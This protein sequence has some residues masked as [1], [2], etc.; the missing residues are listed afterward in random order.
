MVP[1]LVE[2]SIFCVLVCNFFVN[3][4]K[5]VHDWTS[6]LMASGE[7]VVR[8]YFLMSRFSTLMSPVIVLQLLGGFTDDMKT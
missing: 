8:E 5:M 7:A 2:N 6:L 4:I 3:N 1:T